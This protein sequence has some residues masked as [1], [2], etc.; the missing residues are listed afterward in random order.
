MTN[1]TYNIE[2]IKPENSG[3]EVMIKITI[4]DQSLLLTEDAA[5][6]FSATVENYASM[7]DFE[8]HLDNALDGWGSPN[9]TDGSTC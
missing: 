9:W 6:E 4:G 5:F 7:S 8:E 1:P 2:R 3:E